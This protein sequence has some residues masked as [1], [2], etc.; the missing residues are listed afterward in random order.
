M[1]HF[2]LT[3]I[4]VSQSIYLDVLRILSAQIVFFGHALNYYFG[5][6]ESPAA[7]MGDGQLFIQNFA[8]VVFFILSGFLMGFTILK[9]RNKGLGFKF[10]FIDRFSRI[11]VTLIPCL[12]VIVVIDA[13]HLIAGGDVKNYSIVEFFASLLMLQNLPFFEAFGSARPLWSLSAEWWLYMVAGWLFL[14]K[15]TGKGYVYLFVLLGFL[16]VPM[17]FIINKGLSVIFVLSLLSVFLFKE[18]KYLNVLSCAI[19]SSVFTLGAIYRFRSVGTF[20]DLSGMVLLL[21]I[22]I[23]L[24]R[25]FSNHSIEKPDWIKV[26]SG[27]SFS[28]YLIHYSVL[29][30]YSFYSKGSLFF[31][32]IFPY[33]ISMSISVLIYYLFDRN[34][35]KF[36]LYIKSKLGDSRST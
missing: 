27:A 30:L 23:M 2:K 6:M 33:I 34:H 32:I 17:A 5:S 26:L 24:L 9:A 13:S 7:L 29:D 20:Y 3:P 12:V 16:V 31:D 4:D 25:I 10:Y 19:L 18:L 15:P 1:A 11:Y 22:F 21:L 35:K 28:L 14:A 36:S 8:V